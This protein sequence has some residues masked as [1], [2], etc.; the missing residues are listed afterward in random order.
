MRSVCAV[1]RLPSAPPAAREP[2]LALSWEV[3]QRMGPAHRVWLRSD[4]PAPSQTR[5]SRTTL[6]N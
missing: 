6:T 1:E 2:A 5:A 4:D 3:D